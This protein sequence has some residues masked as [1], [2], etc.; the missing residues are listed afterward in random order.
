MH[1][2]LFHAGAISLVIDWSRS[3]FKLKIMNARRV[4]KIKKQVFQDLV[5]DVQ[6]T[7]TVKDVYYDPQFRKIFRAAKKN[8]HFKRNLQN[9]KLKFSNRAN[10]QNEK[11]KI[12]PGTKSGNKPRE[13]SMA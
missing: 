3:I 7:E 8:F 10:R 12:I 1:L 4:K 2:V 9:P 13:K 11:T 6:T 5:Y